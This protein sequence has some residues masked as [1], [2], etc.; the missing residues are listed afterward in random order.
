MMDDANRED[1]LVV[2]ASF[3]LPHE[4]QF[5]KGLL[6]SYGIDAFLGDENTAALGMHLSHIIGG[7]KLMVRRTDLPQAL[8]LLGSVEEGGTH[9]PG[10]EMDAKT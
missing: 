3:R 6:A 1:D 4:A 5:A 9:W 8:E 2:A 7:A 10:E